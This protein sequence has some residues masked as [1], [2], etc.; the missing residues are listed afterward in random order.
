MSPDPLFQGNWGRLDANLQDSSIQLFEGIRRYWYGVASTLW[1]P[2]L[3]PD[4]RMGGYEA[5][6]G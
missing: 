3:E 2:V 1:L 4:Y 5:R 6:T